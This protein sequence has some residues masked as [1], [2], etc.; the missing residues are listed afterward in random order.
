NNVSIDE[1]IK[2]NSI[3]GNL[4]LPGQKIKIPAKAAISQQ[5][6][7]SKNNSVANN[8][9]KQLFRKHIVKR[10]ESLY[11]IA[12]LEK[13]TVS[14]LMKANRIVDNFL[15]PGQELIIPVNSQIQ[16]SSSNRRSTEKI[17]GFRSRVNSESYLKRISKAKKEF[18]ILKSGSNTYDLFN[19]SRYIATVKDNVPS[20]FA[21]RKDGVQY[22]NG[23][24]INYGYIKSLGYNEATALALSFVSSNEGSAS[25]LNFYDGAGSFGFIQFTIKY[26]S[27][28]KFVSLLK[29]NDY[30]AYEKYLVKY[31]IVLENGNLVVYTP[32]GYKGYTRLTGNLVIDYIIK[33]KSLYGPLILLGENTKAVQVESAVQQYMNPAQ[34][35]QLSLNNFQY[36]VK[37]SE[38]FN[39][40]IGVAALTDLSVKLGVN[41]AKAEIERALNQ[42]FSHPANQLKRTTNYQ[43]I[44]FIAS[45]SSNELV[46]KRMQKLLTQYGTNQL[47]GV[48]S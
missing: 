13:I 17:L 46:R 48:V 44:K 35:L 20:K 2:A 36:P 23:S 32:E 40:S 18:Q 21:V 12:R 45:S 1:I 5:E 14:E 38:V 28:T 27:F 3:K 31:G 11:K 30:I 9:T 42:Y 6:V 47:L 33:T 4:I 37:A 41:G 22:N 34:N 29:D 26:G 7:V 15:Y 8:R 16:Y 39:T 43:L 19:N 25:A 24:K 10:G